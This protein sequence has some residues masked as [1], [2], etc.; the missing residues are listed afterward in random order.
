MPHVP[1]A[2]S[3]DGMFNPSSF[4]PVIHVVDGNSSGLDTEYHSS[5]SESSSDSDSDS[6]SSSGSEISE[7]NPAEEMIIAHSILTD[8][9]LE[10]LDDLYDD[11]EKE[12]TPCPS[13]QP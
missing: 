3:D 2:S 9:E 13:P 12:N 10:N 1:D 5:N 4:Q 6:E 11:S 7:L 8:Q